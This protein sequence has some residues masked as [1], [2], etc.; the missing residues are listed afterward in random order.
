MEP[1]KVE[2]VVTI[3][4][5][6]E[7]VEI[8]EPV[9]PVV[10]EPV[11]PPEILEELSALREFKR[12]VDEARIVEAE[13]AAA[14]ALATAKAALE[15]AELP[16]PVE[17]VEPV[18]DEVDDTPPADIENDSGPSNTHSWFKKWFGE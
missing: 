3:P 5:P 4:E 10:I 1:E 7:P 15:I 12:E 17:I 9:E 8:V 2:V 18:I 13:N 16:E 6:V 14:L 11:T